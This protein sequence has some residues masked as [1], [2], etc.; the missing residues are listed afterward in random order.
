MTVLNKP[1]LNKM[2]PKSVKSTLDLDLMVT[3]MNEAFINGGLT[4]LNRRASFL[5]QLAPA[6]TAPP[7]RATAPMPAAGGEDARVV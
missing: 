2:F 6:R 3:T 1:M 4:N 5:A 7:V